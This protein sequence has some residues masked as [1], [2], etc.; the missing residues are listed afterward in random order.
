METTYELWDKDGNDFLFLAVE[1]SFEKG[2]PEKRSGHPDNWQ[3]GSA[4]EIEILRIH[5]EWGC[6]RYADMDDKTLTAI[7]NQIWKEIEQEQKDYQN[8]LYI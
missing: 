5:D 2:E 6:D 3:E 4:D 7:E 8:G 1:Y